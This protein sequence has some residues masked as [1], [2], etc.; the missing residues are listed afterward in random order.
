[1]RSIR[2]DGVDTTPVATV[3]AGAGADESVIAAIAQWAESQWPSLKF[4]SFD[5]GQLLCAYLIGVA[6]GPKPT[7]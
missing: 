6:L 5:G 4:K 2:T 7:G 1:M 3:V